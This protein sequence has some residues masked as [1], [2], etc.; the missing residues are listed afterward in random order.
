MLVK[1]SKGL[2]NAPSEPLQKSVIDLTHMF[3]EFG[4][5]K[6]YGAD[7]E[8]MINTPSIPLD[9]VLSDRRG[10]LEQRHMMFVF[11]QRTGY[12]FGGKK[13]QIQAHGF[14]GRGG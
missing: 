4:R 11:R 1:I 7:Q 6:A 9:G 13:G 10:S 14:L 3:A 2:F 8:F 5:R 12:V